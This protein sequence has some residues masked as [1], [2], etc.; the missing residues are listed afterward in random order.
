MEIEGIEKGAVDG[1]VKIERTEKRV[2]EW[3]TGVERRE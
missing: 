1:T 3:K 2:E